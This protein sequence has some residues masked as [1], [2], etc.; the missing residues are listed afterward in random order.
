[1]FARTPGEYPWYICS[2]CQRFVEGHN[3]VFHWSLG[4]L[5]HLKR[6]VL[7]ANFG[8]WEDEATAAECMNALKQSENLVKMKLD[9]HMREGFIRE[10]P[11]DETEMES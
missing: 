10:L 2:S 9:G 3:W 11:D 6:R 8:E 7:V 4:L 1:M 5:A